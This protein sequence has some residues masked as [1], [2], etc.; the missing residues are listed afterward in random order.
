M[1]K[2]VG[3]G[4]SAPTPGWFLRAALANCDATVIAMRAA[5]LGVTLARLEV[6]VDSSSDDRGIFGL[7]DGVPPGPQAM[8]IRV[9]IAGHGATAQQLRDIVEWA[10][11]HSP[12][13]MRFA[14]RSRRGLKWNCPEP[15]KIEGPIETG[16]PDWSAGLQAWASTARALT[17]PSSQRT[18]PAVTS[19]LPAAACQKA[20]GDSCGA[21][22]PRP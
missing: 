14:G 12:S 15:E 2:S 8:R 3:G 11:R 19:R 6:V 5:Q 21:S 17:H 1:P 16:L 9:T 4:A 22:G 18:T 13:A 20:A 7:G 10:E